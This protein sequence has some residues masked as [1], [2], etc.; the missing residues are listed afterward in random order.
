MKQTITLSASADRLGF[1]PWWS[2]SPLVVSGT[3]PSYPTMSSWTMELW[4]TSH[5]LQDDS[6]A[7]PI[8]SAVGSVAST[9]MTVGFVPSQV[10]ASALELNQE[11]GTNSFWLVIGGVESGGN[12]TILRAG[13]I[14]INPSAFSVGSVANSIGITIIDDW[15]EFDYD[16]TTYRFQVALA[17]SPPVTPDG[18]EVSSDFAYMDSGDDVYRAPV[19]EITPTPAEA[20]EGEIVVVDDVAFVL[21]NGVCYSIQVA[22][23]TV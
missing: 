4:R 5:D 11:T 8:A 1:D 16:G 9:T 6:T 20:V 15:A 21:L 10:S 22:P 13:T 14:E 19:A 12:R 23:A 18:M 17:T 3:V 2:D 7:T